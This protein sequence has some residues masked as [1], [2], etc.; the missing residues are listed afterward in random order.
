MA[1]RTSPDLADEEVTELN[2]NDVAANQ[3]EAETIGLPDLPGKS[4]L[5]EQGIDAGGLS[6]T[7]EADS[8]TKAVMDNLRV[9]VGATTGEEEDRNEDEAG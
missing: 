6:L 1:N 3:L 2:P 9:G 5:S 4:R 7:G 8:M